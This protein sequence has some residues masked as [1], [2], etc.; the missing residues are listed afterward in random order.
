M[1][2]AACSS[3]PP[4]GKQQKVTESRLHSTKNIPTSGDAEMSELRRQSYHIAVTSHDQ[5]IHLTF[6]QAPL[7]TVADGEASLRQEV[8]EDS[9]GEGLTQ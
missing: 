4:G 5:L 3:P 8:V 9:A 2:A 6:L 7:Q 1:A